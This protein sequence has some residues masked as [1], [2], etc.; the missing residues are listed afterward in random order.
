MDEVSE[1]Q[2]RRAVNIIWNAAHDYSFSPDFK[3]YDAD[4]NAELYF[5]CIIGAVRRHYE[6]PKL[7]RV[8]AS[9]MAYEEGDEYEALLWLGLENCVYLR[10]VPERPALKALRRDYAERFVAAYGALPPEDFHLYEHLAYAH[11]CRVLGR[12][13]RENPY[14]R[15]LLDALEFSPEMSTDEIVERAK[16]LFAQ[17]FQINTEAKKRT[18]Q[19][20]GLS[21]LWK[22]KRRVKKRYRKFGIGFADHPEHL[23]QDGEG[24]QHPETEDT[25]TR[26]TAEELRAFMAEK[27]GK[28]LLDARQARELERRLCTG[29]HAN[30]H[31]HLT[32]GE[33]VPGH[34]RNGFEALQKEREAAQIERNRRYYQEHLAQNYTAVRKLSEKIQ[35]SMLLHLQ[36]SPVRANAGQLDGGRVWRGI[37][38]GDDKLFTR[39]EQGNMG[40][41]SVDILLDASTSQKRRQETVS[42]QGYI[43]AEAL[44]QCRIPCRVSSFCSMTGYTILR[45]YR[46]Y[47]DPGSANRR[48]FDYVSNGC[49]RDGLAIRMLH[50]LMNESG[51]AHKILIILSDVKP[52]DIRRIQTK[53]GSDP[54]PYE[55]GAGVTDTAFEVRRARA[56]GIAVICAFTGEDEDL[57]AAKLVYGRDFAAIRSLDRLADSIGQ[58]L[59]NQIRNL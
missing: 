4:G 41:L 16:S 45:V 3:A 35:N 43:I 30:C 53:D 54:I 57:P 10:E 6:Y 33:P 36:P 15:K 59:Q 23:Y 8:F 37:L 1:L 27:Y 5:N 49:N 34:I 39:N 51:C 26:M 31:L 48:I 44:C 22:P 32:K 21:R 42:N 17:W 58:L 40:D 9:F 12:E 56:D 2:K 28:S 18:L 24:I 29:N 55:A 20:P 14:D 46:D 13:D 7:A 50:H 47:L 52:N 19:L 38:L 11:F 25:R